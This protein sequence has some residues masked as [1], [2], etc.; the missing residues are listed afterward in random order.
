MSCDHS[1]EI[2]S[3]QKQTLV[4]SKIAICNK[5]KYRDHSVQNIFQN[6]CLYHRQDQSGPKKRDALVTCDLKN[7]IFH[8]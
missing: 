2:S 3:H 7:D 5:I 1:N 8:Y 4:I 6:C